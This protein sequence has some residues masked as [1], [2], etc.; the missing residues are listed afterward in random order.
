MTHRLAVKFLGLALL[1]SPVL[2]AQGTGSINGIVQDQSGAVIPGVDVTVTNTDTG[3]SNKLMTDATGGYHVPS[4]NPGL[5]QVQAQKAGFT[6]GIRNGVQLT[7]GSDLEINIALTVGQTTTQ[8]VV[9]A[10]APVVDTL[11]SSLSNLVD[12]RTIRDLPL[13]GRSFDQLI[14][15]DSSAPVFR[16]RG[17]FSTYGEAA[18]YTVNGQGEAANVYLMDGIEMEGTG[19]GYQLPGGVL[20]L[21]TGV[22]AIQEFSVLTGNYSAAYG[23]KDGAIINIATK[24]GT[25]TYHGSAYDFLRNSAMDA[26]NFFDPKNIPGFKWNQ[27]GGALGGPIKKDN[28]FFFVNYE[29]LREGKTWSEAWVVPDAN[30]HQGLLP[31]ASAPTFTC[32][33]A[34]GLAN[35]GVNP[36]IAPYLNTLYPL[37]NAGELGGGTGEWLGSPLQIN[38]LDLLLARFDQRISDKD[39]IF[40][41]FSWDHSTQSSPSFSTQVATQYNSFANNHDYNASLEEKHLFSP[42]LI[43]LV[44]TG[45]SRAFNESGGNPTNPT[46][47]A[48]EALNFFPNPGTLGA[49]KFNAS[50][51]VVGAQGIAEISTGTCGSTGCSIGHDSTTQFEGTDQVFKYM[52]KHALQFGVTV[53]RNDGNNGDQYPTQGTYTFTNGLLSFLEGLPTSF[54]G[55]TPGAAYDDHKG[56]R[57]IYFDT[58]IQDDYKVTKNFTINMGLRYEI[59]TAPVEATNRLSNFHYTYNAA[60]EIVINTAPTLGGAA[61]QSNPHDFAPRLGFAWDPFGNGKTAIR[62]GIGIFY[63]QD[64]QSPRFYLGTNAPFAPTVS[65]VNPL[66]PDPFIGTGGSAP[67]PSPSSLDTNWKTPTNVQ[68]NFMIQQQVTSNSMFNIGYVGSEG[69][70]FGRTFNANTD[71]PEYLLNGQVYA[72]DI[73]GSTIYFPAGQ[74]KLNPLLGTSRFVT[75]DMNTSYEALQSGYTQRLS[76]GFRAGASFTW[77]KALSTGPGFIASYANGETGVLEDPFNASLDK[78]LSPYNLV[79]NFTTNVTYDLPGPKSGLSHKRFGGWQGGG[80]FTTHPGT[81]FTVLDSFSAS[82]D[83]DTNAPDRP[84][85]VA[86]CTSSNI[87]LGGPNTYFNAQCFVPAAPG[88]FGNAARNILNGPGFGDLDFTLH[89]AFSVTERIK[90]DFR[91]EIFNILNHSNF[92]LPSAALFSNLGLNSAGTAYNYT[93]QASAGHVT[94][95]VTSSRQIQVGLKLTF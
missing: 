46:D 64:L 21:N 12:D 48:L 91:G 54:S 37:P 4:L 25:N 16:S 75:T 43:N 73:P 50:A 61:Y 35:V 69:S 29:G 2:L 51:N 68:W 78:G 28:S 9:T 63:D 31:C 14:A 74:P 82:R 67:L 92:N 38:N 1:F 41:H 26:R 34:T 93:Y 22:D 76:H 87:I 66:F 23:K 86:G 42:T 3:I 17:S 33:T 95:T 24:S 6:T 15:L 32:N 36:A 60:G 13:N 70:H 55:V 81:P 44:R 7:V 5:Y 49:I 30:A 53:Q 8:T 89:K 11:N 18:V 47:P 58:Y 39:S 79:Y 59:L 71:V 72:Y 90:A 20:G 19:L 85:V 77:S 62:G 45:F 83:G 56:Y 88:T 84:N 57:K 65:V 27:F 10:E 52:G 40:S 94:S 80:I